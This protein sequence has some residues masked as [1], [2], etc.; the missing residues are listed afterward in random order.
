[1]FSQNDFYRI[2]GPNE[3]PPNF[4]KNM[5]PVLKRYSINYIVKDEVIY[6]KYKVMNDLEMIWGCTIKSKDSLCFRKRN[7]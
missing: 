7:E 6:I 1:V 5:K 4:Y 3:I 2:A